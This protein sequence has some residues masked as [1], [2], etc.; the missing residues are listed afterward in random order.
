MKH[1]LVTGDLVLARVAG[2]VFAFEFYGWWD[3]DRRVCALVVPHNGVT[4]L[5][6]PHQI[7]CR[8]TGDRVIHLNPECLRRSHA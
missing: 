3:G 6:A 2:E 4:I 8:A 1:D 7:L 5:A